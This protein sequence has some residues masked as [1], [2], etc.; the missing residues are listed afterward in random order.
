M[1][2]GVFKIHKFPPDVALGEIQEYMNLNGT[3]LLLFSSAY[4]LGKAVAARRRMCIRGDHLT[5]CIG[6]T[7][8]KN[9]RKAIHGDF[10]RIPITAEHPLTA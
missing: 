8:L 7:V 3:T 4:E 2:R 9:H 1:F 10:E 5:F 6:G